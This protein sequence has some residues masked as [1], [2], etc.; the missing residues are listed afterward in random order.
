MESKEMISSFNIWLMPKTLAHPHISVT[1][2]IL[3]TSGSGLA[4]W[5][6]LNPLRFAG[7]S[8]WPVEDDGAG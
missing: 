1:H 2:P 3:V 4:C 6:I 8:S 5:K 7:A